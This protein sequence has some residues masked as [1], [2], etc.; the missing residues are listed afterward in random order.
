MKKDSRCP[1][2]SGQHK[3]HYLSTVPV[4]ILLDDV[5]TDEDSS[6]YSL[7]SWLICLLSYCN[8]LCNKI[9][10]KTVGISQ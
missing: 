10:D 5:D 8:E 4:V 3:S 7:M 9:Q 6:S 1:R 2:S